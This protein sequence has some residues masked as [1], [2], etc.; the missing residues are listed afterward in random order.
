MRVTE[1]L[2]KLRAGK[3]PVRL[4]KLAFVLAVGGS[5][6]VAYS[7]GAKAQ[8][9]TPFPGYRGPTMGEEDYKLANIAV[10]KLL[11]DKPPAIG[12][13]ETWSNP[14]SGTHGKYTILDI[15]TLKGMDCRKV[16]SDVV[17]DEVGVAPRSFTLDACKLPTGEWKTVA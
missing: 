7:A 6:N 17:F 16:S 11:N 4:I 15:F 9:I 14:A 8:M 2:V 5:L 10:G 13:Y 3:M 12:R 1:I